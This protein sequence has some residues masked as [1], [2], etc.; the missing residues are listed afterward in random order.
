MK[1]IK[2]LI[3]MQLTSLLYAEEISNELDQL[4]H[5]KLIMISNNNSNYRDYVENYIDERFLSPK[6][7][8]IGRNNCLINEDDVCVKYDMDYKLDNY[9]DYAEL[10]DSNDDIRVLEHIEWIQKISNIKHI[11]IKNGYDYSQSIIDE[12]IFVNDFDILSSG[13]ITKYEGSIFF[14]K[15]DF[16][17]ISLDLFER[18][19]MKPPGFFSNNFLTSK[20]YKIIQKIK[21]NKVNYID[22]ENFGIIVSVS[23]VKEN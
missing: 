5:V 16:Y 21:L 20:K 1:I 2:F 13:K 22:R 15:K 14:S 3:L 12:K 8:K 9:N 6:T 17:Q 11:K 23:K 4:F 7:I 18:M 19:I 10:L